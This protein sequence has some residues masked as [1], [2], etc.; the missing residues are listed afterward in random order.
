VNISALASSY[1]PM[2]F[3]A[4]TGLVIYGGF[5]SQTTFAHPSH[6]HGAVRTLWIYGFPEANASAV[7]YDEYTLYDDLWDKTFAESQ[8][9]LDTIA[10]EIHAQYLAGLTEDFDPDT[11]PDLR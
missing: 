11:D 5:Q 10:D 8:D 4:G 6:V 2:S 9:L 3:S 1:L 7:R